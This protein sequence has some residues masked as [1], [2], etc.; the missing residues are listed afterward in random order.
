MT[1]HTT[2][3]E[4]NQPVNVTDLEHFPPTVVDH[5]CYEDGMDLHLMDEGTQEDPRL[6]QIFDDDRE[7]EKFL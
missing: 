4:R 7:M 6:I 2:N 5:T 1:P 3:M